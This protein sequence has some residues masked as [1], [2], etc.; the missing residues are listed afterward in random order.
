MCLR[1]HKLAGFTL[2][3]LLV[4]IS[5]I[6][7]TTGAGIASFVNFN[8]RQQVLSAVKDTQELL[9][10]AQVKSRAGEGANDCGA[11]NKLKGYQVTSNATAVIL[12]RICVNATTGAITSTT[13]RSRVTLD[14]IIV[15]RAPNNTITFLALK[16]G[17]DL[18]GSTNISITVTGQYSNVSYLFQVLDTGEI[19]EGAFQDSGTE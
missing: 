12:N 6:L 1:T 9:R 15:T 7:L 10:A 8:D 16:G 14:N 2:I 18:G 11:G 13:E 5:I 3:E 4:V 19:T 17:V